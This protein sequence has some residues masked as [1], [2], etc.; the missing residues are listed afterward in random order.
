M[1]RMK[2]A[3]LDE[4]MRL[5]M[6]LI[7]ACQSS[8]SLMHVCWFFV[9][10][11]ECESEFY[12]FFSIFSLFFCQPSFCCCCCCLLLPEMKRHEWINFEHMK[13]LMCSY[14]IWKF[15]TIDIF[16]IFWCQTSAGRHLNRHSISQTHRDTHTEC[17]QAFGALVSFKGCRILAWPTLLIVKFVNGQR[18]SFTTQWIV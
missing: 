2:R 13:G 5:G 11:V 15:S 8:Y 4:R 3:Q 6:S 16:R 14:I 17:R 9:K 10:S 12:I 18:F 1:G 7:W